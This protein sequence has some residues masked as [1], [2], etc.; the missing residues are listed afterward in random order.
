[1]VLLIHLEAD[2]FDGLAALCC[3]HSNTSL[4]FQM[5][6]S[7]DEGLDGSNGHSSEEEDCHDVTPTQSLLPP[8]ALEEEEEDEEDEEEDEEEE[9]K[10]S[11][12]RA[13]A[14]VQVGGG[15]ERQGNDNSVSSSFQK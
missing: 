14:N 5:S 6:Y 11:N 1:M 9:E 7:E 10:G 4:N 12:R 15:K 2:S 13:L 3:W 8:L